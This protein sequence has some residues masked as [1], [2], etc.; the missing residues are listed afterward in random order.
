M[1][2]MMSALGL[3]IVSG[4][5]AFFIQRSAFAA[6]RFGAFGTVIACGVGIVSLIHLWGGTGLASVTV[7]WPVPYGSFSVAVDTLG[8]L[9]L[10]P[11]FVLSAFSA[12]YGADYMVPFIGKKNIGAAWLF[13]NLLVASM[14]M[15]VIARNTV[16]FLLAWEMMSLASFFL[17]IFEGEKKE[18]RKA[19]LI[20]LIAMHIGTSFLLVMFLLLA[21]ATGSF[22]LVHIHTTT[23]ILPSV[24]FLLAVIGFG[25][26]AGFMP[27]HIWLPEAHPAAP[28]HVSALMSGVMIKTGIY[29]LMRVLMCLGMPQEWWGWTLIITGAVSGVLGVLF[30]LAQHD[31]KRLLAYHSI[32]NIGIIL[33][34]LGL[35]V[36]GVSKGNTVITVFGFAGALLHVINHA[37][38]KG[39]LFLGAGAVVH[40]TGTREIDLLGGLLKKMPVTGFCFLIG[41]AAIC[42]LPPLNGFISEFLIYFGAFKNISGPAATAIASL[43]VIAA[44]ALIGGLAAA[45]FTKAF[46]IVF[47]GE[48]RSAQGKTAHDGGI[49]MNISMV[50]LAGACAV[51]GLAA[52]FV[53][54]PLTRVL[55]EYTGLPAAVVRGHASAIHGPLYM[56][57]MIAGCFLTGV[58]LIAG[59]RL[60]LLKKR[61]S[62]RVLT[63]DCGYARPDARMQYTASSFAQPLTDFFAGILR[64]HKHAPDLQGYFPQHASFKTETPDVFQGTVYRVLFNSLQ[65]VA[66]RITWFQ[67]GRLQLYILYILVSLLVLFIWKL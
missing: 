60:L 21:Q 9:F 42:G 2:L 53:F 64:P 17:V 57:V 48:A 34:G 1:I 24:I 3:L 51:I 44:L 4:L 30:A 45:C 14:V 15:V 50:S 61:N 56:I 10:F 12:L 59:V 63:W 58:M 32:E 46:G 22:A 55:A 28:S 5:G 6:N 19:A 35:G 54:I 16:L 29:G 41:A 43:T 67:H 49:F 27:V 26:K 47:L 25:T 40:E 7:S 65:R 39:L 11:I 20:Y 36:L 31:L 38:F 62:M 23:G 37:F 13:F 18:V 66:A 8:A 33:M 52:P